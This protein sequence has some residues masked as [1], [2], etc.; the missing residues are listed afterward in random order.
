MRTARAC[1][2]LPMPAY[3]DMNVRCTD[4][5]TMESTRTFAISK[6]ANDLV[7]T[8]AFQDDGTN[9]TT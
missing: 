1:A 2:S 4:F 7:K 8:M 5:T 3:S 6:D 9:V